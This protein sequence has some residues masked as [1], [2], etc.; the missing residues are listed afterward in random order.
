MS[1]IGKGIKCIMLG[2]LAT[3]TQITLQ[4]KELVYYSPLSMTMCVHRESKIGKSCNNLVRLWRETLF[5]TQV[6]QRA[7][8][9]F[10]FRDKLDQK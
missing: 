1:K 5:H 2:K 8:K 7:T 4:S 6:G 10:T 9:S 3:T